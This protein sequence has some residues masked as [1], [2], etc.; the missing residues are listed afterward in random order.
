[1]NSLFK[2]LR[3]FSLGL[4]QRVTGAESL[5]SVLS[6]AGRSIAWR[7][8]SSRAGRTL[9]AKWSWEK[10]RSG[11]FG[12]QCRE[13]GD[14]RPLP[15]TSYLGRHVATWTTLETSQGPPADA[16]PVGYPS[17]QEARFGLTNEEA[18]P[19]P[20]AVAPGPD[21]R[22]TD[23]ACRGAGADLLVRFQQSTTKLTCHSRLFM[24]ARTACSE[25]EAVVAF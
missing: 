19:L 15:S 24:C 3:T 10:T 25:A 12:W 14:R 17:P 2:P 9:T 21:L 13:P 7:R 11:P 5:T 8:L 18:L 6:E 23:G 1:M 16:A 22:T 20:G 4:L